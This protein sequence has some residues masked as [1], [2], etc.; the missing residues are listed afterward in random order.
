MP[1]L[2]VRS[3]FLFLRW[4]IPCMTTVILIYH[5]NNLTYEFHIPSHKLRTSYTLW[6]IIHTYVTGQLLVTIDE[7]VNALML[8]RWNDVMFH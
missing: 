1:N 6:N 3:C 4:V 7:L 5:L 2:F 8:G